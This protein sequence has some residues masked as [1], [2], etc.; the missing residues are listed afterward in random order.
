M[1]FIRR[2]Q[3]FIEEAPFIGPP[4]I[5]KRIES[6]AVKLATSIK[7]RGAGTVEFLFVPPDRYYFIEINARIQ[8]EHP[9]SEEITGS[10]L[11][12]EQI[13]AVAEMRLDVR[14]EDIRIEGHSIEVRVNAEDPE[15]FHPTT[16]VV[17]KIHLPCGFGV[18]VDSG[19][20]EGN[21][22]TANYDPLLLKIIVKGRNRN[23]AVA[24]MKRA[25]SEITIEGVKTNIPLLKRIIEDE[26]FLSGRA[27]TK[28]MRKYEA[29]G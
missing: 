26:E 13:K 12:E 25:L 21:E 16:G 17:K 4:E 5:V 10:D 15:T 22:I 29:I 18:R 8:V 9:V 11:I 24:R 27:T 23:E 7:Y 1:W 14:Q 2:H 28:F 19:V 3:K 20:V 6:N